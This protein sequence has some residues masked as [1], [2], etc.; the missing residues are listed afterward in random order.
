MILKGLSKWYGFVVGVRNFLYNK[1]ILKSS[2]FDI[3]TIVIGNISVGGNG[4]TPMVEYVL[5]LLKNDYKL[6]ML[7]RGYGRKTKGFR[8]VLVDDFPNE[9]G[10]E[11]L[12]IKQSFKDAVH[13]FVGEDRVEAIT[14]ILFKY[15]DIQCIVLDDAFQH[16]ALKAGLNIV[17]SHH[18]KLFVDD[19]LLPYGR[20]RE[21]INGIER[22]DAIVVSKTPEDIDKA[23]ID[24]IKSKLAGFDKP[25]FFS[26]I[27]YQKP[28]PLMGSAEDNNNR[29]YVLMAAIARPQVLE[30]YSKK[31]FNILGSVFFKDHHIFTSKDI[32]KVEQK[33]LSF[34]DQNPAILT[35]SKD[36]VRLMEYFA[37]TNA[38]SFDV[39][40]LPI[41]CEFMEE[42]QQNMNQLI[43]D[44]VR[45][46]TRNG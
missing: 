46:N 21:P 20:L 3:P 11:P 35:T 44:Y 39:C 33:L 16:R 25:V 38:F 14:K 23:S 2:E 10:D 31:N 19:H 42:D 45:E 15:P 41:A 13:V 12:Q 18:Q 24:Q 9:C 5:K 32:E 4:K 34:A 22:A 8:E 30:E 1:K 17:L 28:Y 7:S 26:K 6:A 40:V 37:K 43:L 29:A 36:A 27:E